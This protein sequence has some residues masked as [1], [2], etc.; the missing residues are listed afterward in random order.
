MDSSHKCRPQGSESV[1]GPVLFIIYIH[2]IDLGLNNF[3]SKFVNDTKT[4]NAVL[5][6]GGRRR[7]QEN[8]RK[9]SDWSVDWKMPFS[10]NM[11]HIL[12]VGYRN[13]KNDYERRDIKI[14]SVHSVNDLDISHV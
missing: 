11:C 14:K 4:D 3:I 10:I 7:V 8:Y 9:I 13:I 2:D 5:S 6:E 1:L 12:Q